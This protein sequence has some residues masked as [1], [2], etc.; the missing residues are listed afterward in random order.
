MELG[1]L[2]EIIGQINLPDNTKVLIDA[3]SLNEGEFLSAEIESVDGI[4]GEPI[5]ITTGNIV[6]ND[7][8]GQAK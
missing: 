7:K 2:K 3:T 6:V 1:R 4:G 8:D 5:F